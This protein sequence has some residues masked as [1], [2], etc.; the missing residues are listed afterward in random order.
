VGRNPQP[1]AILLPLH[2]LAHSTSAMRWRLG[3]GR[4]PNQPYRDFPA[5]WVPFVRSSSSCNKLARCSVTNPRKLLSLVV[6]YLVVGPPL[7]MPR[8]TRWTSV[9]LPF[10]LDRW[11]VFIK[12]GGRVP[13]PHLSSGSKL[14]STPWERV[15]VRCGGERPAA[16]WARRCCPS[17][18][19]GWFWGFASTRGSFAWFVRIGVVAGAWVISRRNFGLHGVA[20]E[21]R[22]LDTWSHNRR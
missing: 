1:W 12:A 13:F 8:F 21:H 16:S 17:T 18:P 4:Q 2:S 6:P 7:P 20:T 19:V 5:T 22:R 10:S 14:L 11:L 9:P 3:P 15:R